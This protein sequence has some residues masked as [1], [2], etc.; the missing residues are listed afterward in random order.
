MPSLQEPPHMFDPV[1]SC[2]VSEYTLWAP[3]SPHTAEGQRVRNPRSADRG[4]T[5]SGLHEPHH[6]RQALKSVR[7]SCFSFSCCLCS[8]PVHPSSGACNPYSLRHSVGLLASNSEFLTNRGVF[9]VG[10][11]NLGV[12]QFGSHALFP[13]VNRR[14]IYL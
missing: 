10:L 1:K 3:L 5:R 11:C 2:C 9:G 8:L 7:Y 14:V 6:S 12:T 4:F 13:G